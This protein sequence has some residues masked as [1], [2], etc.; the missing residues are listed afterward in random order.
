[1]SLDLDQEIAVRAVVD[2]VVIR[3]GVSV[4]GEDEFEVPLDLGL[5]LQAGVGLHDS[6]ISSNIAQS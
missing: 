5:R 1:M 6:T 3:S 4:P 2:H